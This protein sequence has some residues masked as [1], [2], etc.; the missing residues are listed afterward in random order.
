MKRITYISKFANELTEEQLTKLGED[1]EKS[2]AERNITGVL[3]C[4]GGLFYQ[5][6]EGED[7]VIDLLYKD[8]MKDKRHK[9]V[10]CL[11]TEYNI[12]KRLFPD[13]SM[14]LINLDNSSDELILA[15]NSLLQNLT[16][17]HGIISHYTQPSVLNFLN[18]GINPLS[19]PL[20]KKD[21]VIMFTDLVSFTSLSE[22]YSVEKVVEI[23]NLYLDLSS[24]IIHDA[25][26]EV[27][28]FIGDGILAYFPIDKADSAL[29]AALSIFHMLMT[30]REEAHENSLLKHLYCGCGLTRGLVMEGNIGSNLKMDYTIIG[31]SV[32]VASRLDGLTRE[33]KKALLMS[34]EFVNSIY[35]P[36][37]ILN[38]GEFSIKGKQNSL[39]V[40]SLEHFLVDDFK[41]FSKN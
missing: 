23:V 10:V 13:F 33:L 40:Y 14:K 26:G 29:D 31:D 1:S 35:K 4:A 6:I 22:I 27:S 37:K 7:V 20:K 38:L 18:D 24:K 9:E 36:R 19:I 39:K 15:L 3:A 12:P 34:E 8:I 41:I 11:K 21:R 28:K 16:E 25:G 5:I 2:N 32:N 17:S 30:I